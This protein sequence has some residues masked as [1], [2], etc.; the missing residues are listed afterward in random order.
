MVS[1]SCITYNHEHYIADAIEGFLMQ[2]TNFPYE[3]LIHDD[4]ST[5]RT[6]DIVREYELKYPDLIK[7]IYQKENQYSQG[8]KVTKLNA[9]RAIGKY[10]AVC[11]GDDY[12]T[13]PYKLQK[14]VDYMELNPTCTLCFTNGT[15][16]ENG[17]LR[18]KKFIPW[19]DENRLFYHKKDWSY[20]AGE[21][22]LLGFIPTA[23]L[24]YPAY[25]NKRR[26]DFMKTAIVGDNALKFFAASNGYAHLIDEPTCVY[27]IN[28]P[29]SITTRWKEDSP[30]KKIARS[31]G[32]IKLLDDFDQYSNHRFK[33]HVSL[34]KLTFEIYKLRIMGDTKGM[35]DRRFEKYFQLLSVRN[36]IKYKLLC[37]FPQTFA[38]L[39]YMWGRLNSL[40][41]KR[42]FN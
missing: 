39:K 23:S 24:M 25:L 29:N 11:E 35:R 15:V 9:D 26:P 2:K 12:W 13:D 7:P 37:Y 20:N 27:R 30:E 4:A 42:E 31:N 22:A 32:Y 41:G 33:A 40:R 14:Q 10:I 3:I 36:R 8:V 17:A 18:R 1:I 34:S 19:L 5:D 28:V 16:I 6:P 38:Q 21:V